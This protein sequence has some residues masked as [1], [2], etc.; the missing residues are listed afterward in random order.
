MAHPFPHPLFAGKYMEFPE[1]GCCIWM[2]ATGAGGYARLRYNGETRYGHRLSYEF[3]VGPIPAGMNVCHKCDNPQCI[4]PLH[5]FICT[6][7]ENSADMASK[8]RSTVGEKNRHAAL[9]WDQVREIRQSIE[10]TY[11]LV[12]RYGVS[13]STIKRIR[14]GSHWKE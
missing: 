10:S 6:K 9:T 2:Y 3:H 7:A 14:S 8:K 11:I 13:R 4:A 12:A 5:L 1:T